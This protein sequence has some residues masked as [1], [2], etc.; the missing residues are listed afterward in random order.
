MD[1]PNSL[2]ISTTS[3]VIYFANF[4]HHSL[5]VLQY[6]S[7]QLSA[8]AMFYSGS[9]PY[10]AVSSNRNLGQLSLIKQVY[11]IFL[12]IGNHSP[13]LLIIKCWKIFVSYIFWFSHYFG[14]REGLVPVIH[15]GWVRKLMY[16]LLKELLALS[17]PNNSIRG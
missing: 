12:L 5:F 8:N 4:T 15:H 7:L 11:F 1:I 9:F 14:Q 6:W 2:N 3:L 16:S 13:V 17:K 10:P